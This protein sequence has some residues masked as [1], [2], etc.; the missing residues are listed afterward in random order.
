VTQVP[1]QVGL[2]YSPASTARL[3]SGIATSAGAGVGYWLLRGRRARANLDW[4]PPGG[5]AHSG[6]LHARVVDGD[7]ERDVVVLLHGLAASNLYWG[8]KYDQLA[9]GGLLVAPD[10]LGFGSSPRPDVHYTPD[11]HA[12]AVAATLSARSASTD[13]R[14]SSPTRP[15]AWLPSVSPPATRTGSRVW[16]GSAHPSLCRGVPAPCSGKTHI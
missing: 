2:A 5:R 14:S 10:L 3:L 15:A 4:T 7:G 1:S 6:T 11:D 16:S 8:G 9:S 12:D 13:R